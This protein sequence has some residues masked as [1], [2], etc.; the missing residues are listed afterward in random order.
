MAYGIDTSK[1][2]VPGFYPEAQEIILG[3]SDY[4]AEIEYLDS[5]I[6]SVLNVLNEYQLTENTIIV[7]TSDNGMPF[8]R[9]QSNKL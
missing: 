4:L 2:E 3:M 8:P 6:A 1:I 7:F 9:G 5:T